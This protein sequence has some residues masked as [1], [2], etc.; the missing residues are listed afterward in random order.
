MNLWSS[1]VREM[2]IMLCLHHRYNVGPVVD[3]DYNTGTILKLHGALYNA[4][5]LLQ[6]DVCAMAMKEFYTVSTI[7]A[8][9]AKFC[10]PYI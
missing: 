6:S 3:I 5:C 1:F 9:M 10:I 2:C 8:Q 7:S 4:I